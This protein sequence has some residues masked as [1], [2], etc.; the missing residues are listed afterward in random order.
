MAYWAPL[1][2]RLKN[3]SPEATR[4]H[5]LVHRY[6]KSQCWRD[7][8]GAEFGNDGG[9]TIRWAHENVD[10]WLKRL[11]PEAV[12]IMFGSNDVA[13]LDEAEYETKTREV[14]R[15]SLTNGTVTLLT[16]MPP[17]HGHVEKARAFA[18]AARRIA[19]EER[20]PLIDYFTEVLKRRP[21][22]W[23]GTLR[24]FSGSPGNEYQ[25]PTLM[26][27]DGVHPSNPTKLINDFSEEALKTSGY[28]LRNYLTLLGYALV[29][30]RVLQPALDRQAGGADIAHASA[31]R[32]AREPRPAW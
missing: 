18:E 5:T 12:V 13:Q 19:R 15:R 16:T 8:K 20:V 29:I 4:A 2:G 3:A 1:A 7:W 22:D 25:V 28:G 9:M 10:R 31:A 21:G 24:R 26:A 11:N 23:D 14:V 32:L 27:R 6:M 17:R 30:E